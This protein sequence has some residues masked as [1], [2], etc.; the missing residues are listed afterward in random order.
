VARALNEDIVLMLGGHEPLDSLYGNSADAFALEYTG[1]RHLRDIYFNRLVDAP[2]YNN[3]FLFAKWFE[4]N[5]E[6]LISQVMP[7]NTNFLGSNFVVE[8][9]ALERKKVKYG[10]S[11]IYLG[12]EQRSLSRSEFAL[13]DSTA[14]TTLT[15]TVRRS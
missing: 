15:A 13:S 14:A 10:W 8:S 4:L 2:V 6:T 7:F 1:E 11:D 9:H 5:L 12:R 3:V